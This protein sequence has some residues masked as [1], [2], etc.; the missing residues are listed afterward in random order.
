MKIN[1]TNEV[2]ITAESKHTPYAKTLSI[3]GASN[4][5]CFNLYSNSTSMGTFDLTEIDE[6]IEMFTTFKKLS[7]HIK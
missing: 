6:M 1:I 3:K 7:H 2:E 4:R 5:S